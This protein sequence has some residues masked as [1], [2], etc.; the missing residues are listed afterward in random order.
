MSFIKPTFDAGFYRNKSG[1]DRILNHE[2]VEG[3]LLEKI[4]DTEKT[5][6][7]EGNGILVYHKTFPY[8]EKGMRD[9]QSVAA[10][11]LAKRSLLSQ[12]QFFTSKLLLP[13]H[14]IFLLFPWKLKIKVVEA[15]AN[16]FFNFTS[17]DFDNF[18]PEDKYY[19]PLPREIY[20]AVELFLTLLG[21][22]S[23]IAKHL[24]LIIGT[25]IQNDTAYWTRTEDILSET[26]KEDLLKDFVGEAK[27]LLGLLAER[28]PGR[29]HLVK[30]FAM[31]VRILRFGLWNFRVRNALKKTIESLT[32]ENLQ[33]DEGD[34][35]NIRN[36]MRY[37]FFGMGI[38]ERNQKWPPEKHLWCKKKGFNDKGEPI[39]ELTVTDGMSFP[40]VQKQIEEQH[41]KGY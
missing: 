23:E 10:A 21:V 8:P 29:P 22:N 31:F 39:Y 36:T 19:S 15:W 11:Q 41:A 17:I 30:K 35:Y 24:G 28:D 2:L 26:T 27:R 20:R 5:R 12:L 14:L 16:S 7:E 32:F 3:H 18:I 6:F 25:F 34:R 33:Y 38:K 9:P 13:F 37:R 4:I 1:Q 40:S